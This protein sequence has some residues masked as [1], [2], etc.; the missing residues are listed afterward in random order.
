MLEELYVFI[1]KANVNYCYSSTEN[2]LFIDISIRLLDKS[3]E[4]LTHIHNEFKITEFVSSRIKIK[5]KITFDTYTLS[6]NF[7]LPM[8]QSK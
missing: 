8:I 7:I 4:S 6:V 3:I 2:N 1:P 5:W